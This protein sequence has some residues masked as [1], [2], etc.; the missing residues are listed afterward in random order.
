M[1]RNHKG[2]SAWDVLWVLSIIIWIGWIASDYLPADAQ[3]VQAVVS[4]SEK[5]PAAKAELASFLKVTPNPDRSDLAKI[6]KQI[7]EI[8][9]TET[10]RQVTGDMTLKTPTELAAQQEV[11]QSAELASLNAKRRCS[12]WPISGQSSRW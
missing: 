6:T 9:V 7:N 3:S 4:L 8:L 12:T 10:A 1:K 11:K 2:A 5:S